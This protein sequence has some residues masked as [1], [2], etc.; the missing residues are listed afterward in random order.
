MF[1]SA[2]TLFVTCFQIRRAPVRYRT[3]LGTDTGDPRII[4]V[5]VLAP[6][7]SSIFEIFLCAAIVDTAETSDSLH[8]STTWTTSARR[9][10]FSIFALVSD[11]APFT[12]GSKMTSLAPQQRTDR[13]VV[14]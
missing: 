7:F 12:M 8:N 13:W 4:I 5:D 10:L 11:R 9:G 3:A 6:D 2:M 14:P 1:S